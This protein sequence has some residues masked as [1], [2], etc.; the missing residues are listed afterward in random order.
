MPERGCS[1]ECDSGAQED[2]LAIKVTGKCGDKKAGLKAGRNKRFVYGHD[3][4]VGVGD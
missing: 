1:F 4:G 2:G 3:L